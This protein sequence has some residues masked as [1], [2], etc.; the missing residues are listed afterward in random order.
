[1]P[2]E[3]KS[4]MERVGLFQEM[5]YI[6]V[7][8]KYIP[9][10]YR[11]FNDSAHKDKQ[12]LT[13]GPKRKSGLQAGYFDA[14]FKRIFE[15]EALS[16]PVKL[17]RQ[18]RNQQSK[19]NIGKAFLPSNGEKK[20]SGVGS[21]YG[22][23]AGPV[24][25]MSVQFHPRIPYKSPG[26]N[27]Y[28]S[29]GKKGSGYGY[30][31]I[32][33]AKLDLYSSDPYERA[34]DLYKREMTDHRTKLKGGPFRLNLHPKVYFDSNPFKLEKP[35]P[36][37]KKMDERKHHFAIPF[38]PT[39]PSKSIGGMKAGTFNTYP[40]HSAD[41]YVIRKPKPVTTNKDGKIFRPSPGP[42]STPV[43]SIIEVNVN[44][45]VNATN[46]NTMPPLMVY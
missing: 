44:R 4:D 31:N 13:S 1:M 8:D 2:P 7:G 3:G 30:P 18:Y 32:T 23:I 5:G 37:P 22:T 15:R 36:Q 24:E 25:A 42:K 12:M 29:P 17:A 9:Y 45:M 41:P 26:K 16:D 10:V 39:S 40:S 38:K 21:Y 14:Q 11:S 46:Y 28:T 20:P 33:L 19:K 27:M 34:R 43:K 6:S 35:V